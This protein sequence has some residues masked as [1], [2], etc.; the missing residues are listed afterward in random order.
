MFDKLLPKKREF[1]DAFELHS[2]KTL[3]AAQVLLEMFKTPKDLDLRTRDIEELEHAGDTITHD[4]MA[5]LHKTFVTP[6]DRDQIHELMSCLDDVLDLV[7]AAAEL[8]VLYE[9]K[10]IPPEARALADVLVR[11]VDAVK[12]AVEGLKDSKNN[13]DVLRTCIE[14]NRFE[15]EADQIL[16][17]AVAGLFKSKGDPLLVMKWKEIYEQLETA[18]DRCED[19]ADVIQGIILERA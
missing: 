5:L 19:V 11:S 6:L 13:E 15:N 2:A 14:I 9:I 17:R 18:T 10:E 4:T 1:F 7:D 12:K 16:R 8:V 3:Q